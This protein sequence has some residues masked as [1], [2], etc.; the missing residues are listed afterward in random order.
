MW[1]GVLRF[2][3]FQRKSEC[4]CAP[5]WGTSTVTIPSPKGVNLCSLN[6]NLMPEFTNHL[7]NLALHTGTLV[8][9][10]EESVSTTFC[11]RT[12]WNFTVQ[13]LLAVTRL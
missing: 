11:V 9:R 2:L 7:D 10:E 3:V 12:L 13:S 8:D 6:I 1:T 4:S 5:K